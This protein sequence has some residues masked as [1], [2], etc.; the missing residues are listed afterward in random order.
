[1]WTIFGLFLLT[2]MRSITEYSYDPTSMITI[3]AKSCDVI[4]QVGDA[5]YLRFIAPLTVVSAGGMPRWTFVAGKSDVVAGGTFGTD[6]FTCDTNVP[7]VP[8][9]NAGC[10]RQCRVEVDVPPSAASTYFWVTQP[11]SDATPGQFS[12]NPGSSIPPLP[13][14]SVH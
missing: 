14:L 1:M 11:S 6:R 3:D 5:P 12:S 4:F 7:A 8:V 9:G 13:S 10:A 2:S